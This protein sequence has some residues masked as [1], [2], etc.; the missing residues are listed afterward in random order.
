M[1]TTAAELSLDRLMH[2]AATWY[3]PL[4]QKVRSM[5]TATDLCDHSDGPP[6]CQCSERFL[7]ILWNEQRLAPLL[8]TVDGRSL[9]VVSAGT[10]NLEGGPDFRNAV[11]RVDGMLRRGA[12]EIHCQ[13]ADW[14]R[15]GH[16]GNPAYAEVV[17]HVVWSAGDSAA[18][19]SVPCLELRTH[20]DEPLRELV[21]ELQ[22]N[23]YPYARQVAPGACAMRWALTD[24]TTVRRILR[25][26]A[27]ARFEE[28]TVR[29]QR[30]AVAVGPGQAA[31][32][33]LFEALGY[34]ANRGPFRALAREMPLRRLR[35]LP[36]EASREAALFGAAGL[37]PDPSTA[38]ILPEWRQC[39]RDLWDRWWNAGGTALGLAWNRGGARPLNSP[40]RRLA[41][42]I[43]WL[44]TCAMD[45][46]AWLLAQARAAP[47]PVA[48]LRALREQLDVA[49]PWEPIKDCTVRLN[50]PAR[51]LGQARMDDILANVLLP[52]LNALASRAGDEG[53]SRLAR[54][55]FLD[56]PRLQDNRTL[57]EAAHRFLVPPSRL[58]AVTRNAADQQGL[59]ELY[60]CFCLALGNDCSLCP[61]TADPQAAD[62][63]TRVTAQ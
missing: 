11:V 4:V 54:S 45:P 32:E 15:H 3:A 19:P 34:K 61:F 10:W 12:V 43:A 27:L 37:L 28:K 38:R 5:R 21:E 17:L 46:E 51:L 41:A 56:L 26:A 52:Y 9:E 23:V 50:R 44:R 13:A 40:Q 42:G 22:A 8:R 31:Y 30:H 62:P 63:P 47:G 53:L 49:S 57:Q 60:R 48:L 36:D 16:D 1:N 24:D 6:G 39:V 20:L 35:Q 55:A 7:Q 18:V 25:T 2:L 33:A 58:R 59:M 14:F 29:L